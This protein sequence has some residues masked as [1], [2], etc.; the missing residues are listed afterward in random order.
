[1]RRVR[2]HKTKLR[3][4]NWWRVIE[5]ATETRKK[6]QRW[7]RKKEDAEAHADTVNAARETHIADLYLIDRQS[8]SL[9][10][11][12]LRKAGSA[13]A[14]LDAVNSVGKPVQSKSVGEA[15]AAMIQDRRD[16]GRSKEYVAA[17]KWTLEK[18]AEDREHLPI[19]SFTANDVRAWLA[20][21]GGSGDARRAYLTRVRSL[22]SFAMQ[23]GNRWTRENPAK[24]VSM[25]ARD[26]GEPA[27]FTPEE[28]E[29]ILRTTIRTD[30]EM[31]M[32]FVLLFFYGLRPSE[33]RRLDWAENMRDDYVRITL[34]VA[35]KKK[36]VR[37]IPID[38]IGAR[39]WLTVAR[40]AIR[41]NFGRFPC[42]RN[43]KKRFQAIVRASG[44]TWK[45]DVARHSFVTYCSKIH[46]WEKTVEWAG[47][48]L[49][50]MI[51]HYKALSTEAEAR[52]FFTLKP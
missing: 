7:F 20:K 25:P 12:A 17:L 11:E 39:A 33:V 32:Y 23:E 14:V 3:G 51:E 19:S 15:V 42:P 44:I 27:T 40:I 6:R 18:F 41:E 52:K 24:G 43:W 26:A 46:G 28:V 10:L 31:L 49:A 2:A 45:Q 4:E 48:S 1:M 38:D 22:F 16:A 30:P 21:I 37:N 29:K 35:L 5:P 47:H 8:Q 34:R 50:M 13:A 9:L 36:E